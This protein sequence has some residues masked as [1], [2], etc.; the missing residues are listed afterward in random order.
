MKNKMECFECE[1]PIP[2]KG[3]MIVHKY[4]ESGLDYVTLLGVEEFKCPQCGAIYFEVPKIKQLNT[5]IADMILQKDQTIS[6]DEVRFLRKQLGYS[7]AQFGK[8]ISYDPKS[9]S[10]IENGHQKITSTFDRLIRM[11]YASGKRD[12][13]Y[14]FH[15]LLL[16]EGVHFKRLEIVR[17]QNQDWEVKKKAA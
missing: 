10:R 4:K 7:T 16:G 2:F 6:G 14:N 5:L 1:N 8:L 11:A 3:R 15:D 13:N 17:H 12:L 9:L